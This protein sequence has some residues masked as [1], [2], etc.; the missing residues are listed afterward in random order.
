MF[1]ACMKDRDEVVD[2]L[3]Q[4]GAEL[5][6]DQEKPP[7]S[8]EFFESLSPELKQVIERHRII[9]K[10]RTVLK[11]HHLARAEAS[12]IKKRLPEPE[13]TDEELERVDT[14]LK[15]YP[16]D[17]ALLKK[18]LAHDIVQNYIA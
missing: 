4:S 9:R 14:V 12:R 18:N 5:E 7:F 3:L 17:L 15:H 2:F 8:K 16:G 10:K 13:R 11:M 1:R 6:F